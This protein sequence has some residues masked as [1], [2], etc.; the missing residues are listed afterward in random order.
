[1]SGGGGRDYPSSEPARLRSEVDADADRIQLDAQVNQ[2]LT[3]TL[4]TL[5]DRDTDKINRCL[6]EITEVL[7][8]QVEE[9]D[10]LLLG[11]SVAKH[12]YADGLSDIDSLVVISGDTD[13][14][15][16]QLRE[17][18]AQA[19][20]SAL[21]ETAKEVKVG[22]MA[23]T[24]EYQD[25]TL[26]QLLPAMRDRSGFAISNPKGAGWKHIEPKRFA[27]R[28]TDVNRAMQGMAVPVVKLAKSAIS[29]LPEDQRLSGYHVEA[30]AIAAFE[31]YT[32]PKTAKDM[33]I[34]FFKSAGANVN[35]SIPDVTGQSSAVDDYLGAPGTSGRV[36]AAS[37]IARI[38]RSLESARSVRDWNEIVNPPPES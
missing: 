19:L 10:T 31:N 28:L 24:V 38:A 23:V 4:K 33:L 34:H 11:G 18:F 27:E 15:P 8:D 3:E 2:L 14:T 37:A 21:G 20:R 22:D 16:E 5:N 25:G 9:I 35:R 1:M 17:Q 36:R 29:A 26:I 32:G 7:Q 6:D 30:L 12:T 13:T